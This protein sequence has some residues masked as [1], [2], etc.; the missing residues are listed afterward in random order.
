MK[1]IVILM[2]LISSLFSLDLDWEHD[3]K[4]ALSDA[5]L[6]NKNVYLFIGADRCRW[7]ERFY[8]MTLSDKDVMQRLE[9]EY[10]ILYMNRDHHDIPEKFEKYQVPRHY[11]LDSNGKILY[12]T[13]GSREIDGFNSLLDEVKLSVEK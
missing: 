9:D 6:K 11:F 13:R 10:V 2:V 7:C 4:K 5:K 12:K 3:Y 1:Q 8:N